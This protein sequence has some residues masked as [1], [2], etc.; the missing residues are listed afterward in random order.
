MRFA[1]WRVCTTGRGR[2]VT[3]NRRAHPCSSRQRRPLLVGEVFDLNTDAD[4]IRGGR[5]HLLLLPSKSQ[6]NQ[7]DHI[8]DAGA[9]DVDRHREPLREVEEDRLLDQLLR[10]RQ[11][12]LDRK[13]TR[14]NSSH[15]KLSR[16]PSSA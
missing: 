8:G 4:Q 14:L 3:I 2:A 1:Q 5:I 15:L 10:E 7:G 12:E 11:E 16:M 9:A 13:S 6:S